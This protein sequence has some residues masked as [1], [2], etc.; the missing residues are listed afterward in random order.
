[1]NELDGRKLDHKT[2][3]ELRI[4]A[5]RRVEAGE[6]P[7][8]VI[9]T[10]GFSRARIYGWLAKYREHGIDGLR[11]RLATGRPPRLDGKQLRQ[12]Y[13]LVVGNNPRQLKFEFAL[14]TRAMVRDLIRQ[15]F[16]VSMSEVSVGRLLG[17][18][19]L[20]PQRPVRRAYQQDQALV[21]DWIAKDFPAIKKMAKAEQ[22]TIYFGDEASV[23]S[24]YHSGT[25]WAPRGKTPVVTTTGARFK[26][27]LISAI[28]ARGTL[29]FMATEDTLTAEV[30]CEFLRR[31]ID[32]VA[33]PVY[34]IVDRHS[35]HRSKKVREFVVSTK[36][37]LKLFYLPPYS[38]EL[39]PDELVWNYLKNHKIG[40]QSLTT[41]KDMKER[42][43]NVLNSLS[44]LPEKVSAFF[45]HPIIKGTEM[46]SNLCTD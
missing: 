10:L 44:A 21:V 5:V 18:L 34:L 42:V 1:M 4:R 36:G 29:K 43:M 9:K 17:K 22:A 16:N 8:T 32:N 37:K 41:L 38:P 26:V 39:N 25:T 3:E 15:E 20:S 45:R 46:F 30:F 24:D 31:L 14:W 28:S 23:R 40:R 7:E 27:N 35:V 11:S 12:I 6:S 13:Q 2:L 33:H 19:G